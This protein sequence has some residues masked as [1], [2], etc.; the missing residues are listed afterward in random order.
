MKKIIYSLM[1]AFFAFSALGLTSCSDDDPSIEGTWVSIETRSYDEYD[2]DNNYNRISYTVTTTTTTT[3]VLSGSSGEK[4]IETRDVYSNGTPSELDRVK[5]QITE[6]YTMPD[7]SFVMS[8]YRVDP[9]DKYNNT[10]TETYQFSLT[11]DN[12]I[13]GEKVYTRQ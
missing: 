7:Y 6:W 4:T 1:A 8:T 3:L 2:Y 13:L 9:I 12:F 10:S 5:Y 11:E